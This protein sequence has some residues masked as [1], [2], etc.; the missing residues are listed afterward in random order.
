MRRP[1]MES[2]DLNLLRV[3]NALFQHGSVN[4]AANEIG[5]SPSAISHALGRLRQAF[6]DDLF[7]KGPGGMIPTTPAAE[8]ADRVSAVL[9]EVRSVLQPTGF[10]PETTE[11]H[12]KLRCNHYVTRLILPH[13]MKR[14][15]EEAPGITLT[16]QC[17]DCKGVADDLD[18]G[19]IDFV[20]GDFNQLPT[21]FEYEILFSD[22][23]VW[24][25]R[26]DHPAAS[27][28]VTTKELLQLP[29]IVL[30]T[31]EV[32]RSID[33]VVT[34]AG[35]ERTVVSDK[36]FLDSK[37]KSRYSPQLKGAL[38]TNS[39]FAIPD[40]L[41][42]SDLVALLPGRLVKEMSKFYALKSVEPDSEPNFIEQRLVW[43]GMHSADPAIP[44][45]RSIFRSSVAEEYDSL[46][47]A[48]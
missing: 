7:I 45:L 5:V 34:E 36:C 3:F 23:W 35:L 43:H 14:L 24:V 13:V 18:T 46:S 33:G 28:A 19:L 27:R 2:F 10:K 47:K 31:N 48:S 41:M 26:S 4:A 12:F 42:N 9:L 37:T 32:E 11:R 8:I 1:R 44:W 22:L 38:I 17:D 6:D 25:M 40:I 30:A 15:R 21:R 39:S 20:I 16:V 29:R